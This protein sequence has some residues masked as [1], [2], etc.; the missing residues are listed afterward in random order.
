MFC[1]IL[2]RMRLFLW[3]LAFISAEDGRVVMM[4]C[5]EGAAEAEERKRARMAKKRRL[6]IRFIEVMI[7]EEIDMLLYTI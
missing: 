1:F 5:F 4:S 6:M 3:V 7:D 2:R